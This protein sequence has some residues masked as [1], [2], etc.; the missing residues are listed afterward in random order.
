MPEILM[1]TSGRCPYC[2]RA[3]RLLDAKGVEYEEIYLPPTDGEAR[4]RLA[5][6]TGRYT[7]PQILIDGTPVGG[8]D[9]MKALD[10]R[11]QLDPLIG[12]G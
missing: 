9:D 10:D 1:Y 8:F 11:G 7:V 12:V 2:T 3:K 5:R 4:V 6:L